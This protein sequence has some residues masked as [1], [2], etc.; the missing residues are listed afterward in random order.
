MKLEGQISFE[1]SLTGQSTR[2]VTANAG[3]LGL[4][5][6]SDRYHYLLTGGFSR[7]LS[8]SN[9]F[10]L[11]PEAEILFGQIQNPDR[12]MPTSSQLVGM[13]EGE[14]WHLFRLNGTVLIGS[15]TSVHLGVSIRS[16]AHPST[17]RVESVTVTGSLV[18]PIN[19][20]Y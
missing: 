3:L 11:V 15:P 1:R 18:F 12:L 4:E 5:N 16:V 20:E 7:K 13:A 14:W 2:D 8:L 10:H 17:Q 19:S 9:Y 6:S